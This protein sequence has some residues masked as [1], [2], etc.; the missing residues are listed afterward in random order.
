MYFL[1]LR[2][3]LLLVFSLYKE[4]YLQIFKYVSLLFHVAFAVSGKVGYPWTGLT[5]PIV[6]MLSVI[7]AIDRPKSV[8]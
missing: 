6:W 8:P 4:D 5:I 7:T 2:F 3:G 1:P